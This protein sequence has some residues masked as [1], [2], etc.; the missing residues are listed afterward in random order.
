[1]GLGKT[2]QVAYRKSYLIH[3][4]LTRIADSLLDGVCQRELPRRSNSSRHLPVVCHGHLARCMCLRICS[5]PILLTLHLK[6]I[7][8]WVPT[9]QAVRYHGSS[10]ERA[11]TKHRLTQ[12]HSKIDVCV[13]TY[14]VYRADHK[15]FKTQRWNILVLDEGH[16]IRHANTDTSHALQ[17]QGSL[18][19]LSTSLLVCV[20]RG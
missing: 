15:W 1:M 9:F 19:R 8:R 16:R 7:A 4:V 10:A 6:E 5:L 2:L 18:Y 11:N 3:Q 13:T 17:G 14:E 20:V 12:G